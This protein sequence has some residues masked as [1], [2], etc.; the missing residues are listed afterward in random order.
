MSPPSER[1]KGAERYDRFVEAIGRRL[2]SGSTVLKE[3]SIDM[4]ASDK[5]E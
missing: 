2:A 4:R 3:V 5:H 1:A